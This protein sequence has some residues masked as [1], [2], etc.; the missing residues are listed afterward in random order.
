[1]LIERTMTK[2]VNDEDGSELWIMLMVLGYDGEG[3]MMVMSDDN[4]C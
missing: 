2:I 3:G 1:M 4:N